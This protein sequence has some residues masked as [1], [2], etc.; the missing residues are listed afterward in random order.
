MHR[1]P[2][3]TARM[4]P[5]ID[6]DIV[7]AQEYYRVSDLDDTELFYFQLAK[8]LELKRVYIFNGFYKFMA[9]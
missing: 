3:T 9:T 2:F 5:N 7:H 8:E 1:T 6:E 4:L